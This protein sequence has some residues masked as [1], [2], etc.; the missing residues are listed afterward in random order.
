[1]STDDSISED[2]SY[3]AGVSHENV[4]SN[5]TKESESSIISSEDSPPIQPG[6]DM[7][8]STAKPVRTV[9]GF[10]QSSPELMNSIGPGTAIQH[11]SNKSRVNTDETLGSGRNLPSINPSPIES[12]TALVKDIQISGESDPEIWKNCEARWL[13]LFQLVEKQYQDQI[14]A[15]HEQYQCQ[16]QLIQDEIKALVQIKK[17]QNP[18]HNTEAFAV[19]PDNSVLLGILNG[20]H[21]KPFL[22]HKQTSVHPNPGEIGRQQ[23][24]L[25]TNPEDSAFAVLLSS[26]FGTLSASEHSLNK[27]VDSSNGKN[28]LKGKHAGHAVCPSENLSCPFK[29][30][31]VSKGNNS[32]PELQTAQEKRCNISP[33]GRKQTNPNLSVDQRKM[34]GQLLTSWAQKQRHKQRVSRGVQDTRQEEQAERNRSLDHHEDIRSCSA[35]Q[36][37][38]SFFL[39]K[40]NDSPDS[41]VS[42]ASGLTYWKLD[43]SELYRSLPENLEN[44]S[45]FYL[46]DE[47]I[48]LPHTEEP[49]LP[50]SLKEIYHM[51]QKGDANIHDRDSYSSQFNPSQSAPQVLTLDPTLHMKPADRDS[52]FSSPSHF[53]TA[54]FLEEAKPSAATGDAVSPDSMADVPSQSHTDTDS[55][56]NASS[57]SAAQ[58][59][60]THRRS[61]QKS[62]LPSKSR[63]LCSTSPKV[64]CTN[65]QHPAFRNGIQNDSLSNTD[66]EGSCSTLTPSS[67]MESSLSLHASG[68]GGSDRT[69]S[70][71]SLEDPVVSS[72]V[73]QNLREKHSRHIADL[74]AYYESEIASLKQQLETVIRPPNSIDMERT[75]QNLQERC[76]HLERAL[77]E[78]SSRI[79]DLENKNRLLEKQLVDWPDR[80]DTASTA[81]QV[82]QQRLDE[83]KNSN[84][85]KDNAVNKL[86]ARLRNLE[87]AFQNAYKVSDDKEARMRKE[88]K[89]LQDLLVEYES[90][91]KEHERVKDTLVSTEN[92]LFDANTQISEL[93]RIISKLEA[94]IKQLE[95]ENIMKHRHTTPSHSQA[96][97]V[98]LLLHHPD[99]Y[100][101]PSK[102]PVDLDANRRK[103]LTPGADYS[104]FTGQPLENDLYENSSRCYSPPEKDAT[105]R[106]TTAAKE[107]LKRDPSLTPIMKA[108]IELDGTKATEGRALRKPGASDSRFGSC[109]PSVSFAETCSRDQ[110]SEKSSSPVQTQRNRSPVG[111]RSSS[112][113]NRKV[114]PVSTPTKRDTMITPISAKSSPKR[115]PRENF[116]P[117]ISHL[118]GKDQNCPTWFGVRLDEID[119]ASASPSHSPSPRKRLQFTSLDEPEVSYH[120]SNAGLRLDSRTESALKAV[121]QG[122]VTSRSAWEDKTPA[123]HTQSHTPGL[124]T[125]YETELTYKARMESLAE[126]ERIFDELTQEKQQIEAALSRLPGV[127]GRVTLQA[128][129]DE[130]ALEDRLEKINRDLGSLRMTLKRFHVLRT[131]ANI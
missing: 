91:G 7:E 72:L 79:R 15:Q 70:L 46:Q 105:Q 60:G 104:I 53:N 62:A 122:A 44:G 1:M 115:C 23:N 52:L 111:N 28:T 106:E 126:T 47:S 98:G 128:K 73:R 12:L 6:A 80:Y 42:D 31:G 18:L 20:C 25:D 129:L 3:S 24:S 13:Q 86:K 112:P 130:E 59:N 118:L 64:V 48:H 22:L 36:P 96:S 2:V 27:H 34:N 82:L 109:K 69:I 21:S 95:H 77:T 35:V 100:R 119:V 102:A 89:M 37:S 75:N 107:E 10:F 55:I 65:G 30:D 88:H 41:L 32:Q 92:K 11:S 33:A 110:L 78:A 61:L 76:D 99:V 45:Y 125:P 5:G 93:K 16:I 74:R 4:E 114:S 56:S 49:R 14:L 116:S 85:D 127:G 39:G 38:H 29:S 124:L 26:G 50:A 90:L 57:L 103:W 19:V 43:E 66:D 117:G 81:A 51:K 17:K 54:S 63:S 123:V 8:D 101:S 94:Q 121:K 84:K 120:S 83:M 131:S 87:E 58:I 40:R 97:G 9:K 71:S 67:R 108:L 113:Q 68:A